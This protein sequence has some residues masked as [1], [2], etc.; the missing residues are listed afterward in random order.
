VIFVTDERLDVVLR[1]VSQICRHTHVYVK[2]LRNP[3]DTADKV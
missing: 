2:N 3:Y 1:R